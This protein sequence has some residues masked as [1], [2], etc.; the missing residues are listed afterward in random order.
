[1]PEAFNNL[2]LALLK[3]GILFVD[4]IQLAL[5]AHDLAIRTSF[6]NGCPDFH[7]NKNLI[8]GF[9]CSDILLLYYTTKGVP[10]TPIIYTDI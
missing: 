3:A 4:H 1:M 2:S 10:K 5:A 9:N 6:L 7:D 8:P